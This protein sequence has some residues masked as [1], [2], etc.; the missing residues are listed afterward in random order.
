MI[1]AIYLH[2]SAL[3]FIAETE[4]DNNYMSVNCSTTLHRNDYIS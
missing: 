2:Q 3:F 1:V 4:N